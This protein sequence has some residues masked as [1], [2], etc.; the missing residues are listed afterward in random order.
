MLTR[1]SLAALVAERDRCSGGREEGCDFCG[2]RHEC[3]LDDAAHCARA[4]LRAYSALETLSGMVDEARRSG[5]DDQ[6]QA[7]LNRA[8]L[9]VRAILREAEWEP[10]DV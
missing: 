6:R 2:L 1:E 7:A 8:N 9:T 10:E 4:A 5:Y 3:K